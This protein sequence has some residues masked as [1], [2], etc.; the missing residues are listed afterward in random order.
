MCN[1]TTELPANRMTT[2]GLERQIPTI[3]AEDFGFGSQH[4]YQVAHHHL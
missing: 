3:L 2:E 1:P 4:P